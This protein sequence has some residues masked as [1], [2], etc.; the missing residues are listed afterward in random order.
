MNQPP[1]RAFLVDPSLYTEAYDAALTEGLVAASVDPIWAIR[2]ARHGDTA[3]IPPSRVGMWFYRYSD[4][5]PKVLPKLRAGAKGL[6]HAV[7]LARLARRVGAQDADVIHFQWTVIPALDALAMWL[8]RQSRPVV[9]TVHDTTPFNG[10]RMPFLQRAG[11][12]LP[13]LMADR[14]IV[15]T[16]AGYRALI[17]LGLPAE[18]IAVVPHGPLRLTE[19]GASVA[20][21][22]RDARYTFTVFGEL[23]AYKGLD[24]LVEAVSTLP[25]AIRAAARWVIAGR[26]RMD[27]APLLRRISDCDL[28]LHFDLRLRRQSEGELANILDET[29]CFLFPYRQIDASGAYYLTR[30][31]NKWIIASKLGI[32]AEDVGDGRHGSLVTPGSAQSLADAMTH[33][34]TEHPTPV[35]R[36]SSP[37]WLAI[38]RMTAE[39]YK[40][41]CTSGG[42]AR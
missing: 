40:D 6:A 10:D 8:M 9:L 1:L 22:D 29:D 4:M 12:H 2:P 27:L 23:K 33:A 16:Q 25:P 5:L 13:M 30:S 37:D 20:S 35:N 32:F 21:K 3:R 19:R 34:L 39:V 17:E 31:E 15:H 42:R 38:G 36:E 41:A 7:G 14:V 26:A 18:K 11:F 28:D 24:V